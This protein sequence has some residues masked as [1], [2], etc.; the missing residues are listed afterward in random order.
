[1]NAKSDPDEANPI[2]RR[3]QLPAIIILL[4]N[5][6][7]MW[8]GFF[9]LI[10]LVALHATRDLALSAA[11]AGFVLAMRQFVQQGLGVFLAALS[12]WFGYRRM[13]LLGMLIRCLGFAYLAI[14]PDGLHLMLSGIVAALGGACFDPSSKAALAAVSRGYR[15][16]TIFSLMSNIGNIGMTTGPLVGVALLKLDFKV[17]GLTAASIYIFCFFLLLIFVPPIPVSAAHTGQKHG[18]AQ[19]FGQ[20]GIV[21]R[22]RPFVLI[23]LMLAGYYVLY[24]QINITLPLIAVKLTGNEDNIALIYAIS[25]GLA[26][27]FQYL[28]IK[29]LRMWLQ[30]ITII[31]LGTGLAALGLGSIAFAG[32]LAF[33][34]GCVIIYSLG[35]LMVEPMTYTTTA[36][37]A[38]DDTMASYFGFSSLALALGGIVGNMAGGWLFDLGNQTGLTGLCWITFGIIG[39]IIVAGI[40]WFQRHGAY[41]SRPV[42]NAAEPA[43]AS[44]SD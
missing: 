11:F 6:G 29:V 34:I 31:G 44:P 12:D 21:W 33:L 1:M 36:Q 24:A 4:L 35:R 2:D 28:S 3:R 20:L 18:P 17:V 14:A 19:V 10:P 15:R 43:A 13:M 27:L 22:N 30:P 9:M 41:Q 37:F 8:F 26:I 7:L 38:T 42:V 39:A 32:S 5:T 25:S 23:T 40:F 16:D